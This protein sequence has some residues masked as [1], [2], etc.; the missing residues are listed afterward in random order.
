MSIFFWKKK[1][2]ET[3]P[4]AP[5]SVVN[6]EPAPKVTEQETEEPAV[7]AEEPAAPAEEPAVP[8]EEPA[9][10]AEESAVP[11]EEPAAEPAVYG[12]VAF[13][14]FLAQFFLIRD[15]VAEHARRPFFLFDIL[16]Y[17]TG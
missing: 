15:R 13:C 9:V 3:E 16:F 2:T 1:K 8:A 11:G 17:H 4:A 12:A 10:L 7:P 14:L 6:A 5:E